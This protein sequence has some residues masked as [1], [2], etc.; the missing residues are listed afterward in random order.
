MRSAAE[1][2]VEIA[3]A[4]LTPSQIALVMELSATVAAESR[5]I[6]DEAAERRRERD[7]EYQAEKRR[8][9]SADVGR[10]GRDPFLDKKPPHTPSKIKP[11]QVPPFIPPIMEAWNG[12][13]VRHKLTQIQGITGKRRKVV[14][15]R[16]AEHG[17]D[18][19]LKAISAVPKSDHWLGANGWKGNFDS[20]MRPEHCQ[21]MIELADQ[22]GQCQPSRTAEEWEDQAA[23]YERVGMNDN[24][25]EC[26]RKAAAL[27]K[28]AA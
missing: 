15:A 14:A 16:V 13:A 3:S 27:R 1:I 20:L 10:V 6:V 25:E 4:G 28:L 17:P 21:R 24:A 11:I 7:R 5:P 9:K 18:G 12:M 23:F 22:A 19:V 8:Q 2:M 26:R